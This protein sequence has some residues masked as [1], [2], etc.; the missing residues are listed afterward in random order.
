MAPVPS[1]RHLLRV[2][3][4]ADRHYAETIGVDE[5]AAAAG[6]SRAHFSREFSR[7]FG[8]SPKA[9]LM[10]RRLER[11]AALLRNADR[12]VGE[13]CLDV[14]LVGLGSFTTSFKRHF[15]KTPTKHR[16]SFPLASAQV[17]VPPVTCACTGARNTA[18]REKTGRPRRN[19]FLRSTRLKGSTSVVGRPSRRH[20]RI[21]QNHRHG[22]SS[23]VTSTWSTV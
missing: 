8:E 4:L 18:Q 17:I 16:A 22:A 1:A 10:T 5:L 3:D 19:K 13:I 12:P 9:Y 21:T 20:G 7:T 2:R 15:G 11:A 14:G 6:L 23:A